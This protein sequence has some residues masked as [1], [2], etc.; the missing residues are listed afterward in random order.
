MQGGIVLQLILECWDLHGNER[1]SFFHIHFNGVVLVEDHP[2]QN[3]GTR[4]KESLLHRV[5]ELN[6]QVALGSLQ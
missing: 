5:T 3:E 1:G 2:N 6:P 4:T